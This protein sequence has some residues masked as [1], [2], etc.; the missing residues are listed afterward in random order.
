MASI[1]QFPENAHDNRADA[2]AHDRA[3]RNHAKAHSDARPLERSGMLPIAAVMIAACFA[4]GAWF[5]Y[6]QDGSDTYR[7]AAAPSPANGSANSGAAIPTVADNRDVAASTTFEQSPSFGKPDILV[8]VHPDPAQTQT[9]AASGPTVARSM[10]AKASR[11]TKPVAA[12]KRI[13]R[14]VA[15]AVRPHPIYPAQALRTREQGTVLVLAHVDASGQVSDARVVHRSGSPTLD[16]AAPNEV[17][18]WKFSPALHDGQ[19]VVASVEVPVSYR[20]DP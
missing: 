8:T 19:P 10:L 16:R 3:T 1:E 18:R 12:P 4:A 6:Q 14:E 17:R 5:Y 11:S 20:L 2:V 9:P 13:D 7:A 15:L